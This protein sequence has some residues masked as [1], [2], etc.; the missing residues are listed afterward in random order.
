MPPL[1]PAPFRPL[2]PYFLEEEVEKELGLRI[3]VR[4]ITV[5]GRFVLMSLS[6]MR[7]GLALRLSVVRRSSS[8]C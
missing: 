7:N 2:A 8:N 6:S 5:G 1:A 4:S 3:S